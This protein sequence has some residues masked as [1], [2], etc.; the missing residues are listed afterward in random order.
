[1]STHNWLDRSEYPFAPHY[2]E[3]EGGRMHYVDQGTGHPIVFVHGTP[4][5]SFLYRRLIK[6]LSQNYRCIA[7]DHIGFGLSDK[8]TEWTY[9]PEDHARNLR[10]LIKHLGL[11]DITLV[12]HDFGGPIGLSYAV[13]QPE[14]VTEIVLFNTWMWSLRGDATV[15]RVSRLVSG[16]LGKFLYTRLNLSPRVLLKAAMGDKTKL[17]KAIHRHY[18]DAF[19]SASERTGPWMLARALLGSSE[20]YDHLWQQRARIAD[21][22]GHE[23][24]NFWPARVGALA[25]AIHKRANHHVPAGGAFCAGG[26]RVGGGGAIVFGASQMTLTEGPGATP[27]PRPAPR[28]GSL[29]QGG[30]EPHAQ[31]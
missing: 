1:M 20:W 5:W 19:R 27:Q 12:V 13:E 21:P 24:P 11:R 23:R 10:S 18:I 28:R 6:E 31:A 7:P 14:N 30:V 9:R 25:G 8:P 22:V 17:T 26:G 4:A 3:V 16:G 15:E 2:L 29:I